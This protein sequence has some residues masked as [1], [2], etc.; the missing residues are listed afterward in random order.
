LKYD[1][2]VGWIAKKRR[3][4]VARQY[5]PYPAQT[6]MRIALEAFRSDKTINQ[7]ASENGLHPSQV[8]QWKK[9]LQDSGPEVF[10]NK[11]KKAPQ[12]CEDVEYLQQHVGRLTVQL[13]WLKKKLGVA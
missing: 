4:A 6:K 5:N 11:R 12:A 9:H 10:E 2:L 3:Q 13:E 8:S 7:I 1:G